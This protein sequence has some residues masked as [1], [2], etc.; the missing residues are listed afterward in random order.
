MFKCGIE[1]NKIEIRSKS[2]TA[3]KYKSNKF[4]GN[5]LKSSFSSCDDQFSCFSKNYT[6]W[7]CIKFIPWLLDIFK[8]GFFDDIQFLNFIDLSPQSKV[9][10]QKD[11]LSP[12]F[13]STKTFKQFIKSS[14][15]RPAISSRNDLYQIMRGGPCYKTQ[16]GFAKRT[17]VEY[18]RQ[19]SKNSVRSK[20]IK[21]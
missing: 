6:A 7:N 19:M 10:F 15:G 11:I 9:Q 5:V 4:R 8:S 16:T 17:L 12:L 1:Q 14:N 13:E 21:K 3:R 2:R 18:C 20:L